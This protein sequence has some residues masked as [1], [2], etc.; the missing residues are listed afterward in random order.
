MRAEHAEHTAGAVRAGGDE[1]ALLLGDLAVDAGG[2]GNAGELQVLEHVLFQPEGHR[3]RG[4][5]LLVESV[6][7][8][9][10]IGVLA[11]G[12][13]AGHCP[14][15]L[16]GPG[17]PGEAVDGLFLH[18]RAAVVGNGKW[19]VQQEAPFHKP[20]IESGRGAVLVQSGQMLKGPGA[21]LA[22]VVD[23]PRHLLGDDGVAVPLDH[24]REGQLRAQPHHVGDGLDELPDFR[25]FEARVHE[26]GPDLREGP[27]RHVQQH[28]GILSAGER[29]GHV[30]AVVIVPLHDAG[31]RHLDFPRQRPRLHDA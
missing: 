19:R 24:F 13:L 11:D 26:H 27:P 8:V 16:H 6:A 20:L 9:L 18:H 1:L 21:A 29:D 31:L 28:G 5:L 15:N 12:A 22:G 7:A 25:V 3:L 2:V 23:A 10:E 17:L 4:R 30:A 14:D